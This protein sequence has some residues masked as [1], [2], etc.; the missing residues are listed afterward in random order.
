MKKLLLITSSR[1][2]LLQ[3]ILHLTKAEKSGTSPS[4]MVMGALGR[5]GTG[6][7]DFAKK[8]NI[9]DSNIIRWDMEQTKAGGPY[10]EILKHN[11]FVNC[12]YLSKPITP[13]INTDM[14]NDAERTLTVITDVSCD[15][16]N[17][18]NPI[19]VYYGATTFDSAL[20]PIKVSAGPALDVIAI[21]HLP[22]LLPREASEAFCA[23]LLPYLKELAAG[24]SKT[25]KDAENLYVSKCK[26]L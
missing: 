4:V 10:P 7:C 1:K 26:T 20:L 13:F 24:G 5:C 17:P 21:D 18:H 22:T 9:S 16:T 8:V 3:V 14:L 15:A 25:W 23:D 12:I 19:P 6:A 11:V 2:F